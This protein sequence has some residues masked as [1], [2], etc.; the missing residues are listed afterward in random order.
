MGAD[1]RSELILQMLAAAF[2]AGANAATAIAEPEAAGGLGKLARRHA[3]QAGNLARELLGET[4]RPI[5]DT[6]SPLHQS[7]SEAR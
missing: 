2:W 7:R 5:T 4:A 3:Q 6:A 1:G